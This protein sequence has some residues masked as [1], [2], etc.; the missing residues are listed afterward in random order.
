MTRRGGRE[1]DRARVG[2]EAGP[3]GSEGG[4][5][6]DRSPHRHTGT[7]TRVRLNAQAPTLAPRQ[8]P[9]THAFPEDGGAGQAPRRRTLSQQTH[10]P[11]GATATKPLSSTPRGATFPPHA[12]SKR[13]GETR[14]RGRGGRDALQ[15]A[16]S[17]RP[18]GGPSPRH[19]ATATG[20][21]RARLPPVGRGPAA[22]PRGRPDEEQERQDRRRAGRGSEPAERGPSTAG[23]A[24]AATPHAR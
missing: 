15:T 3:R 11:A 12:A 10:R 9:P 14:R 7:R 2:R 13:P 1:G 6:T 18:P 24:T 22:R 20:H 16:T 19:P 17:S 5:D 8:L 21:V 4:R 23:P